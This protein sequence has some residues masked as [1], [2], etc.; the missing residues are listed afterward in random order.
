MPCPEPTEYAC[1]SDAGD[2]RSESES[3]SQISDAGCHSQREERQWEW[4]FGLVLEDAMGS[5]SEE[6]ESM[7]VYVAGQDAECLL[8]LDAEK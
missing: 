7:I 3:V 2:S 4:R 1:L 6:T 8:K 5:K